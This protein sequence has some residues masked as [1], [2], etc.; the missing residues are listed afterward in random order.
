MPVVDPI[1]HLDKKKDKDLFC[2]A[3]I[4]VIVPV[5]DR[6]VVKSVSEKTLDVDMQVSFDS[7]SHE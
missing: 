4:D 3:C 5:L 7:L 6:E 1:V 2:S